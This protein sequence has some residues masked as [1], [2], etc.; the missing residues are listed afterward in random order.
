MD[1]YYVYVYIDPR[2]YENFYCGKG[3]DGRKNAYNNDMQDSAK[4]QRI[5]A[6]KA[7]GLDPIVRVIARGLTEDQALLIEKTPLRKNGKNLSNQAS[8]SFSEKFRPRDTMHRELEGFDYVGGIYYFNVG[9]G[10]HRNWAD[11]RKFGFI[12]AGQGERWRDAICAFQKGDLIAAYLKG[13]GFVGI[14]R[15]TQCAAPIRSVLVQGKPLTNHSLSCSNMVDHIES[16]TL[17]EHVALV[18]WIRAVAPKDAK[19]APKAA[20]YTT[21]LVRASLANQKGTILFLDNEFD[22]D[23]QSLQE[24]RSTEE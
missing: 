12:S 3:R 8:G 11:Y 21:P 17:C 2:N 14:G 18:D 5:A 24:R 22:V 7:E 4:T 16:N 1:D 23:L 10:P 19:W 9:E 15:I 20:L 6:I 13:K